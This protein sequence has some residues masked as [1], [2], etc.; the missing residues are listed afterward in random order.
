MAALL[1]PS[2]VI[3]AEYIAASA[4]RADIEAR[5]IDVRFTPES[6]HAAGR[7][8]CPLSAKSGH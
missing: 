4:P 7:E 8:E 1:P 6:G 5:V 3:E 2:S